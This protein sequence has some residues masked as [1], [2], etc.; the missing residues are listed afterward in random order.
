MKT[1]TLYQFA[2]EQLKEIAIYAKKKHPNDKPA[3]RQI[4]NDSTHSIC[5]EN[6][7]SEYKSGLLHNYAC[8]LHT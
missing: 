1:K 2:K 3:V 6:D 4:I 8:T 5:I 7:L